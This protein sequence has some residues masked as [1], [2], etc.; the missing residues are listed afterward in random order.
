[1]NS[2]RLRG[3]HLLC[4]LGYQGLG[5]SHEFVSNMTTIYAQLRS[6]PQTSVT[7]IGGVDDLCAKFPSSE[8]YHCEDSHV[9][10][11]DRVILERLGYHEGCSYPWHTLQSKIALIFNASDIDILCPTCPWRPYGLCAE[12]IQRIKR[13]HGLA[14][15]P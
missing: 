4:L 11:R 5:Y 7:L 15:I 8:D 1:M 14:E 13:G 12:G 9:H 6:M 2:I 3:H 10:V